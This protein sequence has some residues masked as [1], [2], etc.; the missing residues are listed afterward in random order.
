M[1]P[2]KEALKI[3]RNLIREGVV[4]S[5]DIP[6]RTV[7]VFFPDR[8][9]VSGNLPLQNGVTMPAIGDPVVCLFLGNGLERGFCLGGFGEEDPIE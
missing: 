7:K 9:L 5:R 8:D 1:E 3:A 4:S 6:G 2:G